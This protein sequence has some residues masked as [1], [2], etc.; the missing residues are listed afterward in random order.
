MVKQESPLSHLAEQP[1]NPG[2]E[3]APPWGIA[4]PVTVHDKL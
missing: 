2:E 3:Q 1:T 4:F